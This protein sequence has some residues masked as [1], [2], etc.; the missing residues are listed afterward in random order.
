MQEL[1]FIKLEEKAI[2]PSYGSKCA[3]GADLYALLGEEKTVIKAGQSKLIHT[4]IAL[5]IPDGL[6]QGCPALSGDQEDAVA[7]WLLFSPH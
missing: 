7:S 2:T 5:Q 1:K 3:A 6:V 4:G